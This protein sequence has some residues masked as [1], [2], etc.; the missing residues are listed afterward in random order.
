M[1]NGEFVL[2]N[3]PL[4]RQSVRVEFLGYLPVEIPNLLIVKGK[5]TVLE[6][7]MQESAVEISQVVVEAQ[8][9]KSVAQNEMT[10][11]SARSF[12]IE[13]TERY[14]GSLGD[15]SRMA[16]N[17][18]G[19]MSVNDQ[20]NDIVIRGNSPVGL[21]W[22]L[23]G[24]DIPNPNHFGAMGTTGGPVSMLN[25]NVLANSDFMTGAFPAEYGNALSGVFDLQMRSGNNK[26]YEFLGQVG[27]GG[28]EAGLEGPISK[29][30]GSSFLI[31]YRY[32][33]LAMM[34]LL[35]F[36]VG[37][38]AAV[39]HYQ[40][41]TF[42]LN[43]PRGKFGKLSVFGIGGMNYIE[44]NDS[45]GDSASYGFGGT[46]LRYSNNM[47][48]SG[49]NYTYF[50][51]NKSR[52]NIKLAASYIDQSTEL[53][54]LHHN[55]E[56]A[57]NR[58]Y[59]AFG[60]T[61]TYI[62]APEFISKIN[63]KNTIKAGLNLKYNDLRYFDSVCIDEEYIRQFDLDDYYMY[64]QAFVQYQHRFNDKLEFNTGVLAHYLE[65]NQ[66]YSIDP[67]IGLKWQFTDKQA[68]SFGSGLHS[69][70]QIPLIYF[71]ETEDT[72]T[73]EMVRSNY[74][75]GFNKSLHGVVGYDL[76]LTKT[77]RI[78]AEAYYQHLF[79]ITISDY[80]EQYSVLNV[81]DDFYLSGYH[82]MKNSGTGRNYGVEL[83]VEKFLSEGFYFLVTT[84]LFE[85]K[86][87]GWDE[88]ERNTKFNGNYVFNALA[89]YEFKLGEYNIL[90]FDIKGMYAGGKRYIPID[91]ELS[92]QEG[93]TVYI[94]E[95]SYDKQFDPYFRINA[96]ITF[97][98]NFKKANISQEWGL[99]LQNLTNHQNIFSQ[100]WDSNTNTIRTYYQQG[101]MPMMTYRILF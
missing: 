41:L 40:D 69:Q 12:S 48:T 89:G 46:D 31:N 14:A 11:V 5:E 39:P 73:N 63:S 6:L 44:M 26:T 72:V 79:N 62:F 24:I 21:L 2:E 75:L 23:E 4:G 91:E 9:N 51:N 86:Y 96:R 84:S 68:I 25:N 15:P 59:G 57:P 52:I 49:L 36:D 101:F 82:N 7:E 90:A 67:R 50:F 54:S 95:Q 99:D 55:G 10:S 88:I 43:F 56:F 60:R 83:T 61:M 38:G 42:K 53:D 66:T 81:G 76:F 80:N 13:E 3:V 77:F 34:S 47:A 64:G 29:N 19:V 74:N 20:R 16:A 65:F 93:Q 71:V 85:S 98:Q 27:F 35:G 22:R 92:K 8:G 100:D 94:W 33:T 32:S 45:E 87:T 28:F 97:K 18:A 37:T 17:F 30:A 78:K 1:S 58:F 70:T